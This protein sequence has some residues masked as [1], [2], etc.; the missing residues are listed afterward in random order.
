M[1]PLSTSITTA[2]LSSTIPAPAIIN[3]STS[4]IPKDQ[5]NPIALIMVV[6]TGLFFLA[7]I[8]MISISIVILKLRR[9]SNNRSNEEG[10][11]DIESVKQPTIE[12]LKK[13]LLTSILVCPFFLASTLSPL[14]A[15][16]VYQLEILHNRENT[17]LDLEGIRETHAV[18]LEVNYGTLATSS[19][20]AGGSTGH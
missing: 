17:L 7:V 11:N 20:A 4:N 5:I 9:H 2:S 18:G 15:P 19:T 14:R 10:E 1:A 16:L 12:R 6:L 8:C 3:D 13:R